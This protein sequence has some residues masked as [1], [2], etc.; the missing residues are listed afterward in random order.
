MTAKARIKKH[1]KRAE[2][3]LFTEF[4]QLDNMHVFVPIYRKDLIE[5][6]FVPYSLSRKREMIR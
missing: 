6:F 1:G 3:I 2:D 4:F 5:K